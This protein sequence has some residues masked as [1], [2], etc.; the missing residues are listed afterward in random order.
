LP[1]V[2]TIGRQGLQ[3]FIAGAT[4]SLVVD[5]LLHTA[6]NG[7]LDIPP[8]LIADAI[9]V[10]TLFVVARVSG[11]IARILSSRFTAPKCVATR[12]TVDA[13]QTE[14][15]TQRRCEGAPR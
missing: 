9:A 15:K 11:P 13:G 7:S 14:R 2:S 10:G 4:I 1:W 5:S 12:P 8:G 3:C 6:T